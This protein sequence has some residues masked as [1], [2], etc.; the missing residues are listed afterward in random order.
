MSAARFLAAALLAAGARAADAQ[1]ALDFEFYKARVQPL[2]LAKRAGGVPCATCHARVANSQLRLQPLAHA[3][4]TWTEDATRANF[5]ALQRFVVPGE[6]TA[7]RLLMHPLERS[8]GGDPFHGGGKPWRSQSDPEWQT[9]AAWVRTGT[10]ERPRAATLDFAFYRARVEPI[11]LK[12]RAGQAGVVACADC[13]ASVASRLRL[14]PPASAAGAWSEEQSR[15]NFEAVR[16]LVV[17]GEPLKS[18][19]LLHPLAPDA[20]GDAAHTGGKFWGSREDSEWRT[21][22]DWVQGAR[23]EAPVAATAAASRVRILQTNAAG[24]DTHLIDPDTNR[25]VGV[26]HGIEV[27]HGVTSAPDGSRIYISNESL[28]T[29]DVV[30]A[31][32]LT[33][34]RRIPLSGRPNNVAIGKDGR[35]VYVGIA[36]PPGA[37]DVIDTP[38]LTNLRSVPVKGPVHNVYVTPDGKYAVSGSIPQ[39]TISVVD[40]KT[41]ELAWSLEL[42]AGIR[43]MAFDTNADGSTRHIYVQLSNFHGFAVVDFAA[44]KEIRRIT[45]PPIEGE[46]PHADGLQG[47]PAHGLGIPPDGKTLWSTSKVFGHAYVYSLP[48][49]R[50]LGSV[51]VGQHPEWVTFTPDS[52]R[53]YVA[54]AGDNAV[55]VIDVKTLKEVARVPVGQVPKRNATAVLAAK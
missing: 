25:V 40:T 18:R 28:H 35:R 26:I 23:A 20:G 36:Q 44:R 52:R 22:A 31:L 39:R 21:L 13:H 8:A 55:F 2:L 38:S 15:R 41:D 12:P 9:L 53:V 27:P 42:S 11:F 47:A 48:E 16:A 5:E 54:A 10:P 4:T 32:S 49:L 1:G 34:T 33:V 30:D 19:L 7:S 43:P 24:D 46:Q 14:E 45:H 29:L 50:P 51:F 37:L 6:P 3:A 17:P